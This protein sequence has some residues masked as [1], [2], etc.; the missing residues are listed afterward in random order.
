P[1]L[2]IFISGFFFSAYTWRSLFLIY[3]QEDYVDMAKARGLPHRMLERRHILRP[4]LPAVLTSFAL[5]LV[6][7]W[8]EII[9]LEKFFDVAGIGRLFYAAIRSFDMPM[10]LGLVV[11]FAYLLAITVFALDLAYAVVDPRVRITSEGHTVRPATGKGRRRGLGRF[12]L[13]FRSSRA[14]KP[15]QKNPKARPPT[16]GYS[17]AE[18][19]QSAFSGLV[20]RLGK[21]ARGLGRTAKQ[22]A[23][24]PSAVIGLAIIMTMICTSIATVIL[25]P[26]DEAVGAWR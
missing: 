17:V 25:I 5:M 6:V 22:I 8:Q 11:S 18:R 19:V 14:G 1:F 20:A 15:F 3:S 4:G 24:Y 2:S 16:P 7:L 9:A 26:Y 13:S 10:I 23:Q 21:G 12:R